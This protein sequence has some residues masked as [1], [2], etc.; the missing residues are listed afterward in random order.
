MVPTHEIV[1]LNKT[2]RATKNQNKTNNIICDS[3]LRFDC[4]KSYE[5]LYETL[6]VY[7]FDKNSDHYCCPGNNKANVALTMSTMGLLQRKHRFASY[8]GCA[9]LV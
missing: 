7:C 5:I 4:F 3:Q 9:K 1:Q 6:I 2:F 8:L